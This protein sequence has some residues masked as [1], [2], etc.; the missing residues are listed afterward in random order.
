M[1]SEPTAPAKLPTFWQ[2]NLA[3]EL[4]VLAILLLLFAVSSGVAMVQL[5]SRYIAVAAAEA[6]KVELRLNEQLQKAS[7]QLR[8]FDKLSQGKN[9]R[10]MAELMSDFSDLYQLDRDL[11]VTEVIRQRP[12]SQVFPRF[13][14]SGGP[15]ATYLRQPAFEDDFSPLLRGFEDS[16]PSIYIEIPQADGL[17]LGRVNLESL[18]HFLR[19]FGSGSGTPVLVV[20]RDGSV[21]LSSDDSLRIPTFELD[22][23]WNQQVVRPAMRIGTQQWIPIITPARSIGA[24]IVILVPTQPL[25]EEQRLIFLL[26]LVACGGSSLLI[27][28]KNLR[29]RRLFILPIA[30]LAQRMHALKKTATLAPPTAAA[31]A[32]AEL[33]ALESAFQAM[34]L[35]IR[36]REEGLRHRASTDEL[37]G[38]LNRRELLRLLKLLLKEESST[39][40]PQGLA[41][42]FCDLDLFKDINDNFGHAA[43]DLV[44]RCV[45]RRI[46][47]QI[48]GED[49]AA[50]V[51]GDEI[52]VVLTNNLEP[53]R[54]LA[55]ARSIR[56]SIAEPIHATRFNAT[57]TASIGVTWAQQQE[58]V[59][60]LMA[61]ADLAMY[62]AKQEGRNRVVPFG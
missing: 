61:R 36:E 10:E 14:L 17:L 24:A 22:P 35:A 3:Q 41:L 34:A 2:R 12:T 59:D 32:F 21:L 47:R 11:Q 40:A 62:Q 31:P 43:G 44:L 52:V 60:S 46:R 39:G 9:R 42:L 13:S 53:E 8:L 37:T 19:Q 57:I 7:E 55:V 5:R 23:H 27:A 45:A 4:A 56:A 25:A 48:R 58:D 15:L 30:M 54:A 6:E 28:L 18:Q 29:M 51:G 49:L 20:A 26:L 38:L 1:A 50:R 33:A 16:R